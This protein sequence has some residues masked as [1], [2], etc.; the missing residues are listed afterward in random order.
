MTDAETF[1]E[2][3]SQT[4]DNSHFIL[5]RFSSEIF[6]MILVLLDHNDLK[7]LRQ[8]CQLLAIEFAPYVFREV[9]LRGN[10]TDKTDN[11]LVELSNRRMAYSIAHLN[12]YV[13]PNK[14]MDVSKHRQTELMPFLEHIGSLK[15]RAGLISL[16]A[17]PGQVEHNATVLYSMN[18]ILSCARNVINLDLQLEMVSASVT[19]CVH[20]IRF[21][22]LRNFRL[23][24]A[25]VCQ[26]QLTDFLLKHSSTIRHLDLDEVFLTKGTWYKVLNKTLSSC[27]LDSCQLRAK[28]EAQGS[29][30]WPLEKQDEV[31]ESFAIAFELD[32]HQLARQPHF[33]VL[34]W[35]KDDMKLSRSF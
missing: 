5:G 22:Y 23:H 8:V 19:A 20:G 18:K 9:R 35:S 12:V 7:R 32:P 10:M 24:R 21:P 4:V 13:N 26:K 25:Q 34:K 30:A 3:S 28:C 1:D 33:P 11:E 27:K 31:L 14:R 6:N 2:S 15:L 16:K 29:C 17:M